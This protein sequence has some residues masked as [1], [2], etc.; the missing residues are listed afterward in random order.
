MRTTA[1]LSA[2][3]TRAL[4]TPAFTAGDFAPTKWHSAKDK[5]EFGNALLKFIAQDFPRGKFHQAL[6]GRLSNSFGHIAH[7][8]RHGFYET[9]FMSAK[10]KIAFLEQCVTW[11]CFGD[12][13]YTFCDVE[14]AVI[15]RLRS[16]NLLTLLRSRTTVEQREAELAQLARLKAR[17]EPTFTSAPAPS[18]PAPSLFP[19]FEGVS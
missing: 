14:R 5:A 17:Y 15:A 19:L 11:P 1:M 12:P 3:L 2:A 7:Y 4:T 18:S 9:F 10:G 16:A 8:D 6:Y 13:A